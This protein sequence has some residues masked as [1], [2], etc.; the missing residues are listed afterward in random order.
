LNR[1]NHYQFLP[2]VRGVLKKLSTEFKQS[3]VF[4]GVWIAMIQDERITFLNEKE[5]QKGRYLIYWMQA[6]QRTHNNQALET[7][8]RMANQRSLP[9][10]VYFEVI[11]NFPEANLRHYSFMLEGLKEVSQDLYHLGIQLVVNYPSAK[12]YPDL[13]AL[14]KKAVMVITDCGYLRFQTEWRKNYARQLPCMMMQVES[15][16]VIPVET[17]SPKE[18]YTAGTFRPKIQRLLQ[19][20]L[21][22]LNMTAP[23]HS[24]LDFKIRSFPIGNIKESLNQLSIDSSVPP[25]PFY[26]GGASQAEKLLNQFIKEKIYRFA[27]LRNDPSLDYLSQMSPYLHFGQISPLYIA[28]KVKAEAPAEAY[29]N[30]IEELIVRREV[31]INYVHYNQYYD[32]FE[33]LPE[34][35]KNTLEEHRYDHRKYVYSLDELEHTL[36]HDAYWNTAQKEMMITGKMHGYMRMY[37]GKKIL[38]WSPTPQEAF[39]RCLYFNNKYELDGRDPNGYTGVAWCFGKHDRAW[40]ERPIFGKIRFMNAHGLE[41]KFEIDRYVEKINQLK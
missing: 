25:S 8:I 13:V 34:W 31:A 21:Q 35:A 29:E 16:V 17:A 11:N 22:P 7:A 38:E 1:L 18:E 30:Y 23:D 41:R 3:D 26:H 14:S 32:Q 12:L 28:L 9:V 39:K 20:Y 15:D 33:G 27:S 2:E 6:S 40:K 24:S 37:W 10:M 19:D 36:T 4:L 5:E